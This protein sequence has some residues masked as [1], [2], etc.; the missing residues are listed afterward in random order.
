MSIGQYDVMKW[1]AE[2]FSDKYFGRP[3]PGS[4]VQDWVAKG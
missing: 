4:V 2:S 1:T 3:D